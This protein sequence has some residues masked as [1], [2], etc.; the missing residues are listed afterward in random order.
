MH[1]DCFEE[2]VK[3]GSKP[4]DLWGANV[5]PKSGKIDFDSMINIRPNQGNRSRS[6]QDVQVQDQI[7][8][9]VQS[10]FQE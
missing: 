2:L 9:V 3:D 8:K 6:V 1:L 10:L 5:Y 7:I 4:E